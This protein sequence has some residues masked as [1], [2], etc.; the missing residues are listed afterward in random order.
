[1]K[2]SATSAAAALFVAGASFRFSVAQREGTLTCDAVRSHGGH[3][4]LTIDGVHDRTAAQALIGAILY[5][6]KSEIALGDGEY[7]DGDLVGCAVV[8]IDG[9]RYGSVE[10]VEHFPASDMLVVGGRMV[11]MVDAIVRSIDVAERAITI[12]PPEG[13]LA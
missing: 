13:L 5:V 12:D 4:L 8:G 7:L 10:R 3:V 11:P 6:E 1:M 2:C 9:T